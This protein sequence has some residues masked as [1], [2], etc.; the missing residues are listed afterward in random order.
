M[1]QYVYEQLIPNKGY[2]LTISESD[3]I[4][5]K[6]LFLEASIIGLYGCSGCEISMSGKDLWLVTPKTS[7]NM[8]P[9]SDYQ[10]YK[11]VYTT[12]PEESGYYGYNNY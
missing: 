4:V 10:Y 11:I 9:D 1:G 6:P 7:T 12:M 2:K 3:L 8:Y 5:Q